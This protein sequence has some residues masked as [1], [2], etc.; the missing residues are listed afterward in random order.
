LREEQPVLA[1][2]R[3]WPVINVSIFQELHTD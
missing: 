1:A 3:V 2:G